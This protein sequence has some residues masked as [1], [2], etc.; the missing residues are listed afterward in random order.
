M[1]LNETFS[2]IAPALV[3]L[4]MKTVRIRKVSEQKLPE[5]AVFIFWHGKMLGGWF[6]LRKLN[7]GALVSL[8]KD[9][10][11][12]SA[13]LSKWGYRLFRGSSS[14]GGKEALNELIDNFADLKYAAITPDGPRGP[15]RYIK[16]GALIVSMKCGVPIIPVSVEYSSGFTL[17]KS[18]D[19]F[20]VPLPFTRCVVRFGK[21]FAYTT[22]L[23]GALLDGFK[24]QLSRE[25]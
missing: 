25:M 1:K 22:L 17:K 3:S 7:P 5:Q 21:P 15:A 13:L 6:A 23:E 14:S 19:R 11:I 2:G 4:L 16:N 12:L 10:E 18:W 24:E 20:E 9:G 8:S